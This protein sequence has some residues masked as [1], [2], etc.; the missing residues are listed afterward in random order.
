MNVLNDSRRQMPR[1]CCFVPFNCFAQESLEDFLAVC[2]GL[3]A[4]DRFFTYRLSLKAKTC[5]YC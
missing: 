1:L 5:G 3:A 2:Y 4:F